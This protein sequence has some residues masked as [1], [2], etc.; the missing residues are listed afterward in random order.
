MGQEGPPAPPEGLFNGFFLKNLP[1]A[2]DN[3]PKTDI[4]I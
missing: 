4:M 2:L 1:K 3:R